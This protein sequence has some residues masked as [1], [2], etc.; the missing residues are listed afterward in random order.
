MAEKVGK[1]KFNIGFALGVILF[2]WVTVKGSLQ[3]ED[4]PLIS[5]YGYPFYWHWWDVSAFKVRVI[6]PVTLLANSILYVGIS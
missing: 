1:Y 3:I 4:G 5:I 6:N 2:C